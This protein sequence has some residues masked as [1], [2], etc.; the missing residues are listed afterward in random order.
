[1]ASTYKTFSSN[2]IVST[3]TLLH[4]AIPLTGTVVSGTYTDAA[5]ETSIKDYSHGMFQSVYD[6]PYLS[7]SAN[8][9]IDLTVGYSAASKLSGASNT[10]NSK[11]INIYNQMAQ[12]LMGHDSTGSI[13]E[14]DED[15]DLTTGAKMREVIFLNFS[16][17]LTKDEIK[18]GS[19]ELK[20]GV[21]GGHP[22]A[23]NERQIKLSDA[24][25]QN[26]YRVNS[27]AGDYAI[28]YADSTLG[29]N[30]AVDNGTQPAGLLFYQAGV[31]VLTASVFQI[32][33]AGGLL[34]NAV[35]PPSMS[36]GTTDGINDVLTGSSIATVCNS[37]RHRMVDLNFNNTTELNS[38]IY[39][40]RANHNEFNYSANPT[41]V[42]GSKIRVKNVSS[43]S[44]VSYITTIGLYSSDNEL[45]AVAKLSEP[46]KK[47]PTNEL[48]LRVRLDY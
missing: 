14:F 19:F 27:P 7:S 42:T 44:P 18:K 41:Y 22:T 31:A 26:D 36:A 4:E 12:V 9:I 43:D 32:S 5:I 46:L 35:H 25:A 39:F 24:N 48:T 34:D 10:Q 23:N 30:L 17:L 38:T 15:G 28:L 40:C 8:H 2:D 33:S 47:D 1:M 3:K 37:F 20:L 13:R 6:Y 29:T 21:S 16:R 45:M 11:K